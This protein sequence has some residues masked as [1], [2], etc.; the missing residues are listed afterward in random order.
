MIF[1]YTAQ[2]EALGY[3][4]RYDAQVTALSENRERKFLGWLAPGGGIYSTINAFVSSLTP[5]KTFDMTTT[6]NG[7]HRAMVPIGMYERVF[8][9]DILP[10][11]LLRSLMSHDLTRAEELGALEFEPEDLALCTFVSPGKEEYGKVLS[12]NLEQI[13]KEG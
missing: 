4:N 8:P 7:S 6:T 13:W 2:D 3:L 12:S 1:G 10:T 9:F 11:F 5:G